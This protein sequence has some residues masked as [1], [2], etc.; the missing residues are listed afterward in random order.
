MPH[1]T[2][3]CRCVIGAHRTRAGISASCVTSAPS[4]A[5]SSRQLP[6][7]KVLN[8]PHAAPAPCLPTPRQLQSCRFGAPTFMR[9]ATA[10]NTSLWTVLCV[11]CIH[12]PRH[13]LCF[14][15]HGP[16]PRELIASQPKFPEAS[17]KAMK[18][19]P[20]DFSL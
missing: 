19:P 6:L 13:A 17:A 12:V 15:M 18:A 7:T 1:H 9:H 5:P 8:H 16:N 10:Q 4:Y 3:G 11:P 14:S 2:V 20:L